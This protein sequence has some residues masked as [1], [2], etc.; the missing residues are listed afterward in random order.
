MSKNNTQDNKLTEDQYKERS[1]D[2]RRL[3]IAA[4]QRESSWP[5]FDGMGYTIYNE[6]NEMADISYIPPKKNKFDSRIVSG[7]THEKD[8]SLVSF[9]GNFNF[10]GTVRCFHKNRELND[11]SVMLTN[12]IRK[13]RQDEDYDDKRSY[14][15]RNYVAQGTSFVVEQYVEE[16]VPD[17]VITSDVDFSRLDQVKWKKKGEK[18]KFKK[19]ESE[20]VDGKK[21]FLEDMHQ[22]DIQKQPR[23]YIVDYIPR[24]RVEAVW[25][26]TKMW[27][28][29]PDVVTNV[30]SAIG[31]ITQWS[32]YS[33]IVFSQLDQTKVERVRVYDKYNNRYQIYLNGI[34]M[35][36]AG[37]PLTVISPSGEYP[38]AKGDADKMNMF[39]YSKSE[40]AKTKVDQAVLDSILRVLLIKFEQGAFPPRGNLTG[41]VIDSSI[42]MQGRVTNNIRSEDLPALIENPGIN[43]S[44][45]SIY[46]IIKEQI[47]NKTVSSLL[48]GQPA[49]GQMT[50]GQYMDMQKKQMLKIGSKIDGIINWEKQMMKLRLWNLLANGAMKRD[51]NYEDIVSEIE[52]DEGK[53]MNVIKFDEQNFEGVRSPYTVYNEEVEYEEENNVPA[54]ISYVNPKMLAKLIDDPEYSFYIEIVP[55]DKNN[56]KFSQVMFVSMITQA[57]NIF[58][59]DSLAVE[60]LKKRY[61]VKFGEKFEDLFLTEEEVEFKQ[62]E[63]QQ[64][65]QE[66]P[67]PEGV[68]PP[69]QQNVMPD[70]AGQAQPEMLMQ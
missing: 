18:V 70:M 68:I 43:N 38:I 67:A 12:W 35:L 50:L 41:K 45:V 40:P 34:P 54:N 4:T 14:L 25:G 2:F 36:S 61:A 58:G 7:V 46:N 30:A 53:T 6:T 13:S 32:I 69:D 64:Q 60:R 20:F 55:V 22:P 3:S 28:D 11:L 57:A 33:D 17:K 29:V 39:A 19:F 51:G 52:T 5:Q 66:V 21:V 59:Y 9:F 27:K 49:G 37:F 15:Y 42:F 23:V 10:E 47:D 56:D 1:E 24:E 48:E 63:A 16:S 8:S 62:I 44:D 65:M 31:G 26:K